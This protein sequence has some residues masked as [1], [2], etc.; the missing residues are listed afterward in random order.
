MRKI[1]SHKHV[2]D[3]VG[4]C[5]SSRVEGPANPI[6]CVHFSQYD[7]KRILSCMSDLSRLWDMWRIAQV[8]YRPRKTNAN[9][10][11]PMHWR[12]ITSLAM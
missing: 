6:E 10:N 4:Y 9:T 12:G 8:D 1:P 7:A 2:A 11:G 5:N 3:A